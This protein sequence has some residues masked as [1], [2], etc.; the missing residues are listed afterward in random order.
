MLRI[1]SYGQLTQ[2]LT[3][4][5]PRLLTHVKS[6]QVSK[7]SILYQFLTCFSHSD[8][9]YHTRIDPDV[10]SNSKTFMRFDTLS[11]FPSCLFSDCFSVTQINM[12]CDWSVRERGKAWHRC[13]ENEISSH[14]FFSLKRKICLTLD[15]L[16]ILKLGHLVVHCSVVIP[17]AWLGISMSYTI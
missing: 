14:I 10:W 6:E 1:H 13:P 11:T 4:S 17:R 9:N 16:L 5:C 12:H 15:T 8:S 7:T 3:C 2:H